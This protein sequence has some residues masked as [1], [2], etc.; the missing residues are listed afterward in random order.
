MCVGFIIAKPRMRLY[1]EVSNRI[2]NIY[3]RWF[4][5][6]DIHVYSIDECFIDATAYLDMYEMTPHQL[7]MTLVR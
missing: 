4:A 3:L 1:M 7:V 2:Y 6:Q 5:P